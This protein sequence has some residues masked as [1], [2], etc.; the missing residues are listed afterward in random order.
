M[1]RDIRVAVGDRDLVGRNESKPG[2]VVLYSLDNGFNVHVT[3]HDPS[4]GHRGV[5]HQSLDKRKPAPAATVTLFSHEKRMFD[6]P[7]RELK[8]PLMLGTLDVALDQ[9]SLSLFPQ[10]R[11]E[12]ERQALPIAWTDAR[13]LR[14]RAWLA[15]PDHHSLKAKY[16]YPQF[17]PAPDSCVMV[18]QS[19]R[20]WLVLAAGLMDL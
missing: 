1:P 19:A 11:G 15:P 3:A 8:N 18:E 17:W 14:I 4:V 16:G 7:M 20:P 2:E 9:G 6:E 5:V 12:I 10:A 13:L